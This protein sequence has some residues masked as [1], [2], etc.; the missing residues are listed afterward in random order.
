MDLTV[1]LAVL[2]AAFMHAGWNVLVKLNLDR[3]LSLFMLQTLMGVM[4]FGML[5]A[6]GMP[7]S[8]SFLYALTSGV[9]HTG[10]NLFLARSYRSGDLSQVYPIARG[11]APLLTLLI[12]WLVA[13]E[14]VSALTA[15][16]VGILVTGIWLTG[17]TGKKELR[18]D[19]MTFASALITSVF[20]ALYTV[21]DGLGG[22]ISGNPS[23]YAALVF[24]LD[25]LFLLG[26]GLRMR[27]PGIIMA[28]VPF[29]KS[30]VFGAALSACA[31]WIVIWAMSKAPIAAVA[32]LRETS[33][34]FVILMSSRVLA[35]KITMPRAIGAALIVA[36]AVAIRMS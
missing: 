6:F 8:E 29:L 22:R 13:H 10:Y 34:L 4:G 24:I 2:A 14:A 32:A 11:T 26:V 15:I 25:G 20:I 21:V 3:F 31:Y 16:A 35:E 23:G 9:L 7:A 33:I 18:L 28:V 36:G 30:G 1:F 27:G 17:L 19:G 12:T 5:A